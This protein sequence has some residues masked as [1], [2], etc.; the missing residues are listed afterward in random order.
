MH[1]IKSV[2]VVSVAKIMGLV[3]GSMGLLFVPLF[4][5]FGLIGS[6]AGQSKSPFV[7]I[8]GIVLAILMP[9]LYGAMGFVM[10]ALGAFLYNLFAR[11][12]GGFELEMDVRPQNLIAPYPI[13]PPSTL[14]PSS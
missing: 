6:V 5:I 7:G 2:G 3:Y 4:L 13:I 9:I 12:V 10:G 1:I 14:T 11:W 8:F